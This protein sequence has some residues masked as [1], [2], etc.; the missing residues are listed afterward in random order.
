LPRMNLL[1][2]MMKCFMMENFTLVS[3]PRHVIY[4]MYYQKNS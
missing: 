3:M 2:D 1:L 4:S